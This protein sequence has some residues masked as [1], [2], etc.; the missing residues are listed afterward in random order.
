MGLCQLVYRFDFTPRTIQVLPFLGV[1]LGV[2]DMLVMLWT[3]SYQTEYHKIQG[4]MARAMTIAGV[5]VSLTS[6]TNLISFVIGTLMPLNE[7]ALFATVAAFVQVTNYI[8]IVFGFGAMLVLDN[9]RRA[10]KSTVYRDSARMSTVPQDRKSSIIQ[11]WR[12]ESQQKPLGY[13]KIKNTTKKMF[14]FC[15]SCC[16]CWFALG[17]FAVCAYGA[18]HPGPELGE[19]I[20]DYIPDGHGLSSYFY[21]YEKYFTTCPANFGVGFAWEQSSPSIYKDDHFASR[22]GDIKDY[23]EA[24]SDLDSIK[25]FGLNWVNEF[26]KWVTV[27]PPLDA[28]NVPDEDPSDIPMLGYIPSTG[29]PGTPCDEQP[30]YNPAKPYVAC[31]VLKEAP[32]FQ[33]IGDYECNLVD[34]VMS[35]CSYKCDSCQSLLNQLVITS[36]YECGDQLPIECQE[37]RYG[38]GKCFS[39]E[40]EVNNY[41]GRAGLCFDPPTDESVTND[42]WYTTQKTSYSMQNCIDW[43]NGDD[44][45]AG[46]AWW[47]RDNTDNSTGCR[48]FDHVG[49]SCEIV[50]ANI[51]QNRGIVSLWKATLNDTIVEEGCVRGYENWDTDKDYQDECFTELLRDWVLNNGKGQGSAS[52]LIWSN[53]ENQPNDSDYLVATYSS[54]LITTGALGGALDGAKI[55]ESMQQ[56]RELFSIFSDSEIGPWSSSVLYD[57][58]DQFL[59]VER[60]L[61][62]S[63]AYIAFSIFICSLIFI[64]HPIAALILIFSLFCTLVEIYG[65]LYW[66]DIN[67]NGMLALNLVVACGI[68]VEFT[69][70]INRHFMLANGNPNYRIANSL[71][72]MFLPVTLGALTTI[73]A[74]SFMA[75]SDIPY[76]RI[77]YFRLFVII[78]G[79]GWFNGVF[80][81]SALLSIAAAIFKDTFFDLG[82]I[83]IDAPIDLDQMIDTFRGE[84]EFGYLTDTRPSG[85][86]DDV[87]NRGEPRRGGRTD[88][89]LNR[90]EPIRG[91]SAPSR[92][93]NS[94]DRNMGPVRQPGMKDKTEDLYSL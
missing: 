77:Y 16:I 93:R 46:F 50:N 87:L 44:D 13:R 91:G 10:T 6:L 66:C 14:M 23:Y 49:G 42:L 43:C 60:Y 79:F 78:T 92:R 1:G 80:L 40:G 33:C 39:Q 19:S 76:T 81:Q 27:K 21:Y 17:I 34:T 62:S 83:S 59:E 55:I 90:G 41:I 9:R 64:L 24:L 4:E 25:L 3:Y 11:D 89:I 70:H 7:L 69:A 32:K 82:T 61:W 22:W 54:S 67:V 58:F 5:S 65:V 20:S 85:R 63:L 53:G 30:D 35:F 18:F 8:G 29:W 72:S 57:L 68:T 84:S 38:G 37:L 31:G 36:D 73:L 48:L 28:A 94:I 52:Q 71:G 26:E 15:P 88:D 47:H 56:S 51:T 74:V 86:T 75:F 12:L 2:D 45:C